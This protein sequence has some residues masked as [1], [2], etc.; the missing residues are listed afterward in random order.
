VTDRPDNGFRF[1]IGVTDGD[2]GRTAHR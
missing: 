1:R 2:V